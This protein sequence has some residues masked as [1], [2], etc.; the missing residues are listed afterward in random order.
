MRHII[1]GI[2]FSVGGI[3]LQETGIISSPAYFALYGFLFGMATAVS[4]MAED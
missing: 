2:V 4:I 3:T 1:I